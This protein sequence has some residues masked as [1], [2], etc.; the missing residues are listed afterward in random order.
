MEWSGLPGFDE[1]EV[2]DVLMFNFGRVFG[3]FVVVWRYFVVFLE[4]FVVVVLRYFVVFIQ[5]W[6]VLL[7]MVVLV[8]FLVGFNGLC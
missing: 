4:I 1:V 2:V 8:L 7:L 5:F 3:C 6:L